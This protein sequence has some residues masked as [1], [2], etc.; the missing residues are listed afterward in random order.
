MEFRYITGALKLACRV[1]L[2]FLSDRK[3]QIT[4]AL[5]FMPIPKLTR[6]WLSV[7]T[8]PTPIVQSSKRCHSSK[9]GCPS[10]AERSSSREYPAVTP[11]SVVE[12]YHVWHLA[13]NTYALATSR[14]R[15]HSVRPRHPAPRN[16]KTLRVARDSFCPD[17]DHGLPRCTGAVL[18]MISCLG[19]CHH[20]QPWRGTPLNDPFLQV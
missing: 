12:L 17:F 1:A 4:R 2:F 5:F 9:N 8:Q 6:G 14:R 16:P 18:P 7:Q 13:T 15:S 3:R 19:D 11:I 20:L 10:V